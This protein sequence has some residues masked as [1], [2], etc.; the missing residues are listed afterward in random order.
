MLIEAN[1]TFGGCDIPQIANG[2][3][4]GDLTNDVIKEV[5]SIKKNILLSKFI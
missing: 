5:F 1:M 2:P 3:L 4:Y